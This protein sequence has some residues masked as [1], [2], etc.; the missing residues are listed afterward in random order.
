[1]GV[2]PN[3]ARSICKD[4]P[5]S[6]ILVFKLVVVFATVDVMVARVVL[7]SVAPERTDI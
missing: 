2:D 7:G 3:K 5:V 4:S 1:M 6:F